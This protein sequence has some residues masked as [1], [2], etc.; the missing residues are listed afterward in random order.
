LL[1]D[2]RTSRQTNATP[3]SAPTRAST[4]G[5]LPGLSQGSTI[6]GSSLFSWSGSLLLTRATG[7]AEI[8]GSARLIHRPEQSASDNPAGILTLDADRLSA[9]VRL[10][11]VAGA[12]DQLAGDAEFLSASALGNVVAQGAD[13]KRVLAEKLTYDARSRTL[14][15]AGDAAGNTLGGR[16][17]LVDPTKPNPVAAGKIIWNLATDRIEVIN[18]MPISTPR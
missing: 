18:P 8:V 11:P 17:T 5:A 1:V 16:V 6:A 4:P 13:Q 10:S 12:T 3:T 9:K 14:E 15:A 7:D 2:E